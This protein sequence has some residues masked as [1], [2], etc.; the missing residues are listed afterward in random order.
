MSCMYSQR[1]KGFFGSFSRY[2]RISAGVAYM[3][4]SMS[5]ISSKARLWNTPS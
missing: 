2:S 4:D 3:R 5:L 1:M